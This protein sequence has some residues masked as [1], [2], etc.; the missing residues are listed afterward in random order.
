M[1]EAEYGEETVALESGD[2]LL[3]YTDGITEA[4]NPNEEQFGEERLIETVTGSLDRPSTE[5]VDR[6][7]DAVMEFSG[8]EPQFDDLTLMVLRV[9]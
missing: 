3:L 4:I 7:R 9:V 8:D 2:L 5:I 6:V 1:P